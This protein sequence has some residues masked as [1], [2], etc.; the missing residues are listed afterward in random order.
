MGPLEPMIGTTLGHYRILRL[1]GK[2]GIG[3]VYAAEDLTL[4][5]TVALK[6]LPDSVAVTDDDLDRFEREAKAVASLNHPGIVTLHS[7]EKEGDTR[8]ITMELVEGDPLSSKIP[9]GGFPFDT[10][11]GMAVEIADAVSTAHERGITHRDLKPA[12]VLVTPQGHVKILDFGLAKLHEPEGLADEQPTR[13]LTGEGRIVGTVAYMSP[14]Q[15]EGRAVDYR[16]DIFSLGMMLYEMSTGQRPFQSDTSLSVLS[17][18]LRDQPQPATELNPALPGAFARLI[19][20]CLRK[21]PE[22]RYQSAKDLRNELQTLKEELDSGELARPAFVL[23]SSSHGRW[24]FIVGGLGLV[25]IVAIVAALWRPNS[26]V[27][28]LPTL[29]HLQLTSACGV[30][31]EP[32]L[33]PDG[34]WFVFVS[35]A[36][37]NK[38]IQ[39]QSVGG[40]TRINLTSDSPAADTAPAFLPDGEHIA[41]RSERDGGG[42]FIMGRTGEAPR[43]ITSKGFNP[44]WSPDGSQLVFDTAT[45]GIA[46]SRGSLS[47]LRL[48]QI[49]T[50]QVTTLTEL[51][52]S[53][54]AWSPNGRFVAFWGMGRTPSG[55]ETSSIRDLWVIPASGG[56]PWRVTDDPAV[57][58]SPM[59]NTDGSFLYFVSDRGG[60][61]NLWRLP[62]H[63]DTGLP[64]GSAQPVTTPAG[65]A[66][67]A[68]M[69]ATGTHVVYESRSASGN[70]YR[71]AFDAARATIGPPT[72]V[73]TGSRAFR[74]VD[75][76]P[77]SKLLILGTG[78]LQQEDLFISAV[79][80]AGLQQLTTDGFY[81]R[82]P[83]WSPDSAAVAFYSNRS[84]KY[85]IWTTTTG[86]QLSQITDVADFSP[87][88]PRWSTDGTRMT[89]TDVTNRRAVVMFDPRTPWKDQTQDILPTPADDG[90][91]LAGPGVQWSPDGTKLAGSVNGIVTIYDTV[92]RQYQSFGDVQGAV[93]AWLRDGRLF[94]G[95]SEAPRLLDPATGA[96]RAL[97][98]SPFSSGGGQQYFRLSHDERS[99]YFP[100][101]RDE[102]DIW[103]VELGEMPSGR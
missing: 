97:A 32:S 69:S 67:R 70:I 30:E 14:E 31:N 20:T 29:Q 71:A 34:R 1:V 10:L 57:D 74:F 33:S 88:Y 73:T 48:V 99:V 61:M 47:E 5:R 16:T 18:V 27:A 8:F 51:D 54:P 24:P 76:S 23:A 3:E 72:A 40:Q 65:Y 66:G 62:M 95:P 25:A 86:G 56:E 92:S 13:Q 100:V 41:F 90:S 93:F 81:D 43:R 89:F 21:D 9:S 58:W 35:S 44:A 7:F 80:G 45:F 75:P 11:L 94:I 17:A 85:E 52:A 46:T 12:N 79:D 91:Y 49:D 84:G 26:T 96:V 15:A 2:G 37:G 63:A 42:I 60:S 39:L 87:L 77:D 103:L 101:S 6:V 22:R 50:G 4:D 53:N 102:G 36:D 78:F 38:D 83:H 98:G 68:H 59:W 19:K 55:T 64:A 82:W 28:P